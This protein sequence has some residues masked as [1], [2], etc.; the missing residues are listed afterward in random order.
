MS[1]PE[2]SNND[3]TPQPPFDLEMEGLETPILKTAVRGYQLLASLSMRRAKEATAKDEA[4]EYLLSTKSI[5]TDDTAARFAMALSQRR[6]S[7][8]TNLSPL[9]ALA[10][11]TGDYYTL[12][13]NLTLGHTQKSSFYFKAVSA[14]RD[15]VNFEEIG[16][17]E[18]QNAQNRLKSAQKVLE[19]SQKLNLVQKLFPAKV[20]FP[21]HL[22]SEDLKLLDL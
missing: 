18:R 7:G 10:E 3:T 20:N 6:F 12:L 13:A 1:I 17:D 15:W 19:E 14:F 11:Q 9:G 8:E 22:D 5:L 4:K 21:Y 16:T 2:I